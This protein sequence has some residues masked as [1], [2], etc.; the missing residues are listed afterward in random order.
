MAAKK[1][2]GKKRRPLKPPKKVYQ[3]PRSR[4]RPLTSRREEILSRAREMP[5]VGCWR[6]KGWQEAGITMVLLARERDTATVLYAAYLVDL[7]CLGLKNAYV[8]FNVPRLALPRRVERLFHGEQEP[9]DPAFAHQLIYGAIDFARK[10]GFEPHEDFYRL[11]ADK[12]LD[13]RGTH[14]EPYEIEFG[15]DGKPFYVSGPYDSPA[16][17][18]RVLATLERT[19]PGEYRYLV[20]L[21]DADEIG[22]GEWVEE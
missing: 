20:A 10:Y 15:K 9:C 3:P 2:K 17:A 21:N 16:F 6:T 11:G 5:I 4:I 8:D 22:G 1:S 12:I 13:P 7:Y 14:P 18:R 19:A